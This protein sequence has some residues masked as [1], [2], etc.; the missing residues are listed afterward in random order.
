MKHLKSLNKYLFRYKWHLLLGLVFIVISDLYGVWAQAY[1]GKSIDSIAA[2]DKTHDLS[3]ISENDR[4]SLFSTVFYLIGIFIG[5]NIIKGFFLFCQR[6]TIIVMSRRIEYDLKNDIYYHYQQ[7]PATFYQKGKTGDIMNRISEDVAKVRM[8]LGPAIMYTINLAVLLVITI[9]QMIS[10]NGELTF[11]VLLPLPVMAALIF[12]VSI[13]I[14]QKSTVLQTKQSI[15]S[16]RSQEDFSAIRLIKTYGRQRQMTKSFDDETEAYR[17]A[18]LSLLRTDSFFLPIMTV[19]VGLSIILTICIGGIFCMQNKI[20]IGDIGVFVLY[21]NMLTW[22]FAMVG[23]ISSLVQRAAASQERINEF[24]NTPAQD[25]NQENGNPFDKNFDSIRFDNV[26][27]YYH[28]QRAAL[29]NISFEVK[30][31]QSVGVIGLTGSGKTTLA[32]LLTG[33]NTDY[34]GSITL[35]G[36]ELRTYNLEDLRK[37]LSIVPQEAYLFSE[38]I[39]K[40]IAFGTKDE[41][42]NPDKVK[43][44]AAKAVVDENIEGFEK[45]Y[46]TVVGER[47][48]TLSGGQKQRISIARALIREPEILIFD[49]CMSAVD[50]ETEHEILRNLLDQMKGKTTFFISHRVSTVMHSDTILVLQ[51]GKIIESGTHEQLIKQGGLYAS[52][53]DRQINYPV[54][55]P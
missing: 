20:T 32:N 8:Y 30:K 44:Y 33:V 11:Y 35:K 23:W 5:F 7:L 37:H 52:L 42:A 10:I 27:F 3:H 18:S 31:G 55:T 45:K 13:K 1:I 4:D 15:L 43:Y 22:P 48:V 50:A 2:F 12:Y 46:E 25:L 29:R 28:K 53:Y 40:N 17:I 21:V 6:Q 51:E 38:T 47:G 54:D 39:Y 34:E 49:D 41:D 16:T 9:S 36:K 19:F 14:N 24:M 26:N